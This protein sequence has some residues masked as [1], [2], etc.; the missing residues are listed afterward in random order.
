MCLL[1]YY[2][3]GQFICL[4]SFNLRLRKLLFLN[5]MYI[6]FIMKCIYILKCNVDIFLIMNIVQNDNT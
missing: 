2:C 6:Y 1:R 4:F 3:T 5:E